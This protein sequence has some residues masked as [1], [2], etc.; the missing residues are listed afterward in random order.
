[1]N[2]NISPYIRASAEKIGILPKPIPD[3]LSRSAEYRPEH[4]RFSRKLTGELEKTTPPI[5]DY[6]KQ[7][8][9]FLF[10]LIVG[11]YIIFLIAMGYW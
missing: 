9:G 3:Y 6:E 10:G 11:S 4:Y 2:Q 1:M 5:K 7:I 8:G